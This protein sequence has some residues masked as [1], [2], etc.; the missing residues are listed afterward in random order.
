M[1]YRPSEKKRK[2]L[3]VTTA[4]VKIQFEFEFPADDSMCPPQQ[5]QVPSSSS[6]FEL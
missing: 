6:N 2:K 1:F 4:K 5:L 3:R